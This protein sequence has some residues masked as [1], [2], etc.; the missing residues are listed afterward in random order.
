M[1]KPT[2]DPKSPINIQILLNIVAI[3]FDQFRRSHNIGTYNIGEVMIVDGRS[4][5]LIS[6]NKSAFLHQNVNWILLE[7][8]SSHRKS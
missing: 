5:R 3:Y 4:N 6:P 7:S 2:K 8:T 1:Q